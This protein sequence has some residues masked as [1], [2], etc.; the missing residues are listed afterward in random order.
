M[1]LADVIEVA[2]DDV[3]HRNATFWT[4]EEFE[5]DPEGQ[6]RINQPPDAVAGL[7]EVGTEVVVR[8]GG[9]AV[10]VARATVRDAGRIIELELVEPAGWAAC[11]GAR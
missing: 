6:V 7:R 5:V 9:R 2:I 1:M 10:K 11:N 3:S 8:V 4:W